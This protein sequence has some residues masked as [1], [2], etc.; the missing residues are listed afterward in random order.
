MSVLKLEKVVSFSSESKKHPSTNLLQ[1]GPSNDLNRKWLAQSTTGE[2]AFVV[3]KLEGPSVINAIDIGNEGSAYIEVLVSNDRK[4]FIRLLPS[5]SFM[6]PM[7]SRM[8]ETRNRIRSFTAFERE[9]A[10]KAWTYVKFV[11]S[12]PY[13]KNWPFG[14][15][16][17]ALRGS[18]ESSSEKPESGSSSSIIAGRS[19]PEELNDDTNCSAESRKLE[20]NQGVEVN[21]D[22]ECKSKGASTSSG[23][24]S[25][26]NREK[27]RKV[28]DGVVFVLSGFQNPLRKELRDM[29]LALG[30]RYSPDWTPRCTHLVS[31]FSNTPKWSQVAAIG[32]RIV[33]KEWLA[34]CEKLQKKVPWKQF[35]CGTYRVKVQEAATPMFSDEDSS[36]EEDVADDDSDYD[37]GEDKSEKGGN[38]ADQ[39]E[40]RKQELETP[41]PP[42]TSLPD[43]CEIDELKIIFKNKTFY[44]DSDIELS[45]ERNTL[46]RYIVG[47]GGEVSSDPAAAEHIISWKP[48]ASSPLWIVRCHQEN[49]WVQA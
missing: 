37:P 22:E 19:A 13:N 46:T 3:I 24:E 31:A 8:N 28:L 30:A 32:G 41:E 48:G 9:A 14:I 23:G 1:G 21:S 6:S 17:V 34:E 35:K 36:E 12:Q 45:E 25:R 43:D 26:S 10:G 38:L 16:F 4:D 5:S 11:C 44:L 47:H 29:A 42:S 7:E 33:T 39:G 27:G 20:L 2:K 18:K 40:E 49:R 15:A